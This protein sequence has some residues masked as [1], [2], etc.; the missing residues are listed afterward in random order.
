MLWELQGDGVGA[1][2]LFCQV[3]SADVT[4]KHARQQ[5]QPPTASKSP[6]PR[7]TNAGMYH[8]E[9]ETLVFTNE[10]ILLSQVCNSELIICIIFIR[11]AAGVG[12]SCRSLN[13]VA[14]A[15]PPALLPSPLR[16]CL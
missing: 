5:A 11:S 7:S 1:Q 4:I 14:L 8:Q 10:L 12:D 16:S 13:R 9:T 2:W 15:V 6:E 3:L